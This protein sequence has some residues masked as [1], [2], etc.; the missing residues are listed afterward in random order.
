MSG[1]DKGPKF[2]EPATRAR[3]ARTLRLLAR[4]VTAPTISAPSS[5]VYG[6]SVSLPSHGLARSP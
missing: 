3:L 6:A 2:S 5:L 4:K 1:R